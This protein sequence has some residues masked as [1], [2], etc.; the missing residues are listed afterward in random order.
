M[1]L[2]LRWGSDV[3]CR[4]AQVVQ[5]GVIGV[6]NGGTY[7]IDA[8]VERHG[9]GGDCTGRPA[10]AADAN[11]CTGGSC[12]CTLGPPGF[13]LWGWNAVLSTRLAWDDVHPALSSHDEQL[14]NQ[15]LGCSALTFVPAFQVF[16]YLRNDRCVS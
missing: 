2:K 6:E 3:N 15:D 7:D 14:R 11:R 16:N 5:I 9:F 12:A 13:V 10:R 8:V 4:D 1:A